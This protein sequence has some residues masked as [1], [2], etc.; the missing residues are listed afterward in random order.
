MRFM[1]NAAYANTGRSRVHQKR[2]SSHRWPIDGYGDFRNHKMR[3]Q[4]ENETEKT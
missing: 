3:V 1:P 2:R 4:N